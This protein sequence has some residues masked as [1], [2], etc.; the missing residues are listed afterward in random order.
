MPNLRL[1]GG[2]RYLSLFLIMNGTTAVDVTSISLEIR[3][4]PTWSNLQ[5]YQGYYHCSDELPNRM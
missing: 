4:Q 2:S 3:F 1:H 5:A